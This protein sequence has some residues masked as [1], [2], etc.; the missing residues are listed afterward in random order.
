MTN[1]FRLNRLV[2][3]TALTLVLGAGATGAGFA[4]SPTTFDK[5]SQTIP[6]GQGNSYSHACITRSCS[7]LNNPIAGG[8][9]TYKQCTYFGGAATGAACVCRYEGRFHPG[10]VLITNNCSRG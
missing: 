1:I 8:F 4:K 6:G 3:A 10:T 5:P 2:A 9:G 7:F